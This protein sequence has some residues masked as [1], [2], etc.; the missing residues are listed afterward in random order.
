MDFKFPELSFDDAELP[1]TSTPVTIRQTGGVGD[2]S[3]FSRSDHPSSRESAIPPVEPSPS[4]PATA[5]ATMREANVYVFDA[6]PQSFD[7][8]S[9]WNGVTET[10][11]SLPDKVSGV[12]AQTAGGAGSGSGGGGGT[13]VVPFSD[14]SAG[15]LDLDGT[16][17]AYSQLPLFHSREVFVARSRAFIVSLKD[18][19]AAFW[20]AC[21]PWKPFFWPSEF[22]IPAPL[23]GLGRVRHNVVFYW[24]NYTLVSFAF[25]AL[26]IYQ[27]P[28][29][30]VIFALLGFFISTRLGSAMRAQDSTLSRRITGVAVLTFII[31]LATGVGSAVIGALTGG[32]FVCLVHSAFHK[33]LEAVSGDEIEMDTTGS[34]FSGLAFPSL[35]SFQ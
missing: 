35:P 18:R 19:G 28:L 29:M 26:A 10:I 17:G 1:P 22:S 15:D 4:A 30:F 25:M 5:D 13:S 7:V 31:M 23:E 24:S 12:I 6:P 33:P 20:T 27:Q 34:V 8:S 9:W 3:T 2:A 16:S 21:Q 32:M 11:A 14:E